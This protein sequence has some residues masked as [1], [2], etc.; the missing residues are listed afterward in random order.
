[1][2]SVS[3]IG[4]SALLFA[5]SAAILINQADRLDKEV[6]VRAAG[7]AE[8]ILDMDLQR[9]ST[10]VYSYSAWDDSYNF[11]TNLDPNYVEINFTP[12]LFL[13]S[14]LNLAAIVGVD[15]SLLMERAYDISRQAVV[16]AP[17][18]LKA[19]LAAGSP[20]LAVSQPDAVVFGILNLPE[21]LLKVVGRAIS[22]S[23]GEGP[24]RSVMVFGRFLD[25]EEIKA[26]EEVANL[27]IEVQPF[28]G[29]ALPPDFL[30]AKASLGRDPTQVATGLL[31]ADR[32][33]AYTVYPDLSGQPGLIV[34]V[35]V[36]RDLFHQAQSGLGLMALTVCVG[37]LASGLA[38][39]ALV[40][41]LAR[42]RRDSDKLA[43]RLAAI[44]GLARQLSISPG[45]EQLSRQLLKALREIT[46]C[47][48]VNLFL[49][50]GDEVELLAGEGG[51][52]EDQ[53]P[54]GFRM[55]VAEG[56][57][58]HAA[59]SGRYLLVP[60]V[61]LS[62]YYRFWAGLP[63]TRSELAI[64]VRLG[65]AV[66]AVLDLEADQVNAFDE[67]DLEA[68][69]ILAGQ[70]AVALDNSRLYDQARSRAVEMESLLA[71]SENR[72]RQVEALHTVD[73]A[74]T[75]SLG[76]EVILEMML[77]Q[78]NT[79]L[80][81]DA[82]TV[83]LY[84]PETEALEYAAK[85]G[86]R[87]GALQYT[88]LRLGEGF[89]GQAALQRKVVQIPN[90]SRQIEALVRS[91]LLAQE[92]FVSYLGVPLIVK[93]ELKGVLEIFHRAEFQPG[94][95]W[96]RF[97]NSL[98][99]QAAIAIENATLLEGME[100]A[101]RE[102]VAAYDA[103]IEGWS[104]ALEMRDRETEGHSRRVTDLSQRLAGALGL[105]ADELIHLRRG[106]LL[107]DI[108]KM[109]V[110]DFILLKPGP[111]NPEEWAIM[112]R[113]PEYSYQMLSFI[114]FLRPALDIPYCHHEHWDGTGY[115]RGLHGEEIPLAARIF[116]V[117]DVWDA[118]THIRPYHAA[119][120]PEQALAYLKEQAGQ[121]F[122]PRVVAEFIR[123][124]GGQPPAGKEGLG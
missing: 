61:Q 75:S 69:Q 37:G 103:T 36:P 7:E 50:K 105:G 5:L 118:V 82:A 22:T 92:E 76:L 3:I 109:A 9:I 62:P 11:F 79:L 28:A 72:L 66:I 32:L 117:V 100:Q 90:L 38:A 41:R 24:V 51:Y 77:E 124:I 63:L 44:G 16:P 99:S 14:R 119:W 123:L 52:L 12:G 85:R 40:D 87:T 111:L 54:L 18:G 94:P 112:R 4:L 6:A 31:P 34:R 27:S 67:A 65:S 17:A 91:T 86:F 120:P 88:R 96:L 68:L 33:A 49:V 47:Y 20:L 35:D 89:A 64:P 19:H 23:R 78:V 121:Q 116:A 84:R 26:W 114:N 70:L 74:V 83:L 30:E 57:I 21:G 48:N 42:A 115:P 95:D 71:V 98:A 46:G 102:L 1:M 104:L 97:L 15:G 13:H 108:G 73:L 25:L 59:L 93:D 56:I 45:V 58:G 39:N 2:I 80:Q 107:H 101:N 110:P 81:V 55:P 10:L 29:A 122:D 113:H 43:T 8:K 60:D 53:P 106:A